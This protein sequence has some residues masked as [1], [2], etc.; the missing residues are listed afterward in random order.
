MTAETDDDIEAARQE[1]LAE[2]LETYGVSTPEELAQHCAPGTF[3]CH[4]AL[5]TTS[6]LMRAVSADLMDHPAVAT[7]AEW[8]RLAAQAHDLLFEL[9][10]AIGEAHLPTEH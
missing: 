4:E 9:Y 7:R 1:H 10:Q 3:S 6:L 8:F 5:H 2:L